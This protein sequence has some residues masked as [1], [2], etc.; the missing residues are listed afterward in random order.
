MRFGVAIPTWGQFGDAHAVSQLLSSVED[1]GF[2]SAWFADHVAIPTYARDRFVPPLLEPITLACWALARHSTL[3]IGTDVLVAPY[4]HPLILAAMAGSIDRLSNGRLT[5]GMGIG[6]LRGEF[7]ALGVPIDERG[8]ITDEV[9][10]ALRVLWSGESPSTFKG[11]SYRF[12]DVLPTAVPLH[13]VPVW[14]GGNSPNARIRA[15]L[16]GDGWHPLYPTPAEYAKGRAEIQDLRGRK[17]MTEPFTFS[18]S[19]PICYVTKSAQPFDGRAKLPTR[20]SRPEYAYSPAVPTDK[21]G[22]PLLSGTPDQVVAD[23]DKYRESGVQHMVLRVWNSWSGL[24]LGGV[25]DQLAVW[26]ETLEL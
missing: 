18:Y 1:L 11:R 24:D 10:S 8:S 3:A 6:Y 13:H 2:E 21:T 16:L 20:N 26:A 5:L 22:R 23:I 25:I 15:A 4:R 12:E 17:G 14:V 9:L 19:A 7:S